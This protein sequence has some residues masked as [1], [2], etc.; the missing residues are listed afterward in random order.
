MTSSEKTSSLRW[1]VDTN[2]VIDWLMFNDPY[3]NPMRE[4]VADGRLV[5]LTH[6]PIG[7]PFTHRVHVGIIEHQPINHHIGI[8]HPA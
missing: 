4:R 3:M 6:P 1:V 8:H 7:H 2:V 5:V